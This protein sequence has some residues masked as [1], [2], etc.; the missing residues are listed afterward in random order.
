MYYTT[1]VNWVLLAKKIIYLGSRLPHLTSPHLTTLHHTTPHL[2]LR[3]GNLAGVEE[4]SPRICSQILPKKGGDQYP[5]RADRRPLVA[6]MQ[7]KSP[8]P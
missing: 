5:S 7:S 1:H 2:P 4:P 6:S 3:D 8:C